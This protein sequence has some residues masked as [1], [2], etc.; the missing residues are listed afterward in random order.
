MSEQP[1]PLKNPLANAKTSISRDTSKVRANPS[2]SLLFAAGSLDIYV[3][4]VSTLTVQFPTYKSTQLK[5]LNASRRSS[6]QDHFVSIS[7]ME[8]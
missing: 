1:L 5:L 8:N 6:P 3:F 4:F 7:S 2:L